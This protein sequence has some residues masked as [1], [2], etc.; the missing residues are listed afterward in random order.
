MARINSITQLSQNGFGR[1]SVGYKPPTLKEWHLPI[2]LELVDMAMEASSLPSANNEKPEKVTTDVMAFDKTKPLNVDGTPVLID[3]MGDKNI[4]MARLP[5]VTSAMM[6]E[7]GNIPTSDGLFSYEIFGDTPDQRKRQYAY[8]DLGRK[9]FHPYIFECLKKIGKNFAYCAAG[10]YT[11]RVNADGKLEKTQVGDEDYDMSATGLRWLINNFSKFKFEKNKSYIHN[12]YVEIITNSSEDQLFISKFLVIPVFYRDANFS[13]K[14]RDIPEINDH[15]RRL[16]Q[17]TNALRSSAMALFLNNT[18]INIQ[19]CMVTIRRY[20]Q[21]LIEGKKGFLKQYVLGKTTVYAARNVITQPVY[22]DA[23][24]PSEIMVDMFHT[25]FPIATCCS[26]GYP[27][28]ERWILNFFAKEFEIKTKKQV[29][30]KDEKGQY[31]MEYARIGDVSAKYTP[32]YIQK[33]V[34]QY[35]ETYGKRFEPLTIPMEDGT[36][37]YML[38]TGT[39]YSTI[40]RHPSAPDTARRAMTWTDLLYL[41]CVNTL[42]F[43]GKMAYVTRYPMVDYFNTFP[44]MIR[45]TSTSKTCH[46]EVSGVKYP[47]YPIVELDISTAEVSTR[48]SDSVTMDNIYLDGIGG[49][50]D[51]DTVS[52]RMVFSEEAN[53]EAFDIMTDVK[54]FVSIG[55]NLVQMIK[56][57]TYLTYFAM[58]A[59]EPVGS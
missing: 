3:L 39:P 50:Y 18:E 19:E 1:G 49:D 10:Q 34:E 15:Y 9:F 55:G 6:F 20:G 48:F 54:H 7:K 43:G 26:M 22:A 46:M 28:I 16:L 57:E 32:A 38:F 11:W 2:E 58:T 12:Q 41:A 25:G 37:S 5:E 14:S 40:P 27:F 21:S 24:L 36:E 30:V 4:E 35:M 51:G 53:Q 33:K 17:L 8:I 52:E 47:F 45:V 42:E 56:N 44:T 13:G 31:H 29:L 23:A 59:R